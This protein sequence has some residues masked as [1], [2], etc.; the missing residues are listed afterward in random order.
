VTM[1][2][3]DTPVNKLSSARF[4]PAELSPLIHA[5]PRDRFI[6]NRIWIDRKPTDRV[7]QQ[8]TR[9]R[10]VYSNS[11]ASGAGCRGIDA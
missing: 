10:A 8:D 2:S 3:A 1:T 4:L 6:P 11:G 7:S 5:V 9:M